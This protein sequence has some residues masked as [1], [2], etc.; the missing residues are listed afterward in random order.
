MILPV[1]TERIKGVI[2]FKT[3]HGNLIV[4]PTAEDQ[5][6]RVTATVDARTLSMLNEKGI[7]MVPQLQNM[8]QVNAYAGLRPASLK[9]NDYQINVPLH[10][11]LPTNW[12]TVGAI[13][14][15]GLTAALG[16]A[17]LVWKLYNKYFV[18][19]NV[20]PKWTIEV[21][22]TLPDESKV[23]WQPI[24]P[25]LMQMGTAKS[26]KVTVNQYSHTVQ[27]PIWQTGVLPSKL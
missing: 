14:S 17:H 21:L 18:L 26:S 6:E 8:K 24:P 19:H 22:N 16:I 23:S 2:V 20:D 9:Y 7:E 4:G 1:P 27:H 25:I 3:I 11:K 10:N 5:E 12:I 13:R 15:T